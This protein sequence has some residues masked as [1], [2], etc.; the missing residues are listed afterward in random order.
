MDDTHHQQQQPVISAAHITRLPPELLSM[1]FGHFKFDDPRDYEGW[2]VYSRE[3]VYV[4][5]ADEPFAP[6]PDK[7]NIK[8]LRLT[9]KSFEDLASKILFARV[10]MSYYRVDLDNF[11]RISFSPTLSKYVRSLC[12]DETMAAVTFDNTPEQIITRRLAECDSE[13]RTTNTLSKK[14]QDLLT[15]VWRV[16][17]WNQ[18]LTACKTQHDGGVVR[19]FAAAIKNL[20][21]LATVCSVPMRDLSGH[22]TT[23]EVYTRRHIPTIFPIKFAEV[24]SVEPLFDRYFNLHRTAFLLKE[25]DAM[26]LND[27][28]FRFIVP[29]LAMNGRSGPKL[30]ELCLV[31][32]R[33]ALGFRIGGEGCLPRF[34][35]SQPGAFENV[36][37]IKFVLS[38]NHLHHG[39]R[40][41]VHGQRYARVM[42]NCIE[43]AAQLRTL[44]LVESIGT[45]AL[46]RYYAP[47]DRQPWDRTGHF[48]D[49]LVWGDSDGGHGKPHS[50]SPPALRWPCLES[51]KLAGVYCSQLSLLRF[52][53]VHARTITR[54]QLKGCSLLEFRTAQV[55]AKIPLLKLDRLIVIP[56]YKSIADAV[57]RPVE[58]DNAGTFQG[59]VRDVEYVPENKLKVFINEYKPSRAGNLVSIE[60][61]WRQ[62]GLSVPTRLSKHASVNFFIRTHKLSSKRNMVRG[63]W[64]SREVEEE[65]NG[66]PLTVTQ[67]ARMMRD[68][69]KGWFERDSPED[70]KVWESQ[71]SKGRALDFRDWVSGEE[72]P[73]NYHPSFVGAA[74][75]GNLEESQ[76]SPAKFDSFTR[77]ELDCVFF[78]L[79]SPHDE[80]EDDRGKVGPRE[81]IVVRRSIFG[82]F[83]THPVAGASGDERGSYVATMSEGNDIPLEG[84]ERPYKDKMPAIFREEATTIARILGFRR[85]LSDVET[86]WKEIKGPKRG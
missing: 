53:A 55:L 71:R 32:E 9:C 40:Y 11:L 42:A 1:I 77:R 82:P 20:E 12:W 44:S 54:L 81:E 27:G 26:F 75:P 18:G 59:W 36:T 16:L 17:C 29:A 46:G 70:R 31:D 50:N 25:P 5:Y 7:S 39:G 57:P 56:H 58:P 22:P 47:G 74:L 79:P 86:M 35:E 51:L 34:G 63:W 2:F 6:R 72:G 33:T 45:D 28:F 73:Q 83:N 62:L 78:G 76:I 38:F 49:L 85:G 48:F 19:L 84:V 15:Y 23:N 43:S 13:L 69:Q 52:L 24:D 14:H 8:N 21:N 66:A 10:R 4:Q 60:E 30:K 41:G 80:V 61:K 37:N 64:I 3:R 67:T 68:M 65:Q